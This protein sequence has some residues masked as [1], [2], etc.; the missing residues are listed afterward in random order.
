[1]S[2]VFD[3]TLILKGEGKNRRRFLNYTSRKGKPMSEPINPDKLTTSLHNSS[4]VE[5]AVSFELDT[6]GRPFRVREGGESWTQAPSQSDKRSEFN[7]HAESIKANK[8]GDFHNPY[9]FIPAPPGLR[10]CAFADTVPV[11]NDRFYFDK[12]SG[13]LNV[14]MT[15]ETPVLLHDTARITY[16]NDPKKGISEHKSYPIRVRSLLDH[17][18]KLI[19]EN[20]KNVLVPDITPT[21]V[22][23]MLRAAYEAITN[24]RFSVFKEHDERLAYRMESTEGA[25]SVPAR[26][27]RDPISQKLYVALYTGTSEIG[28]DGRPLNDDDSLSDK[29]REKN[30][31]LC[32][33]WLPMYKT[34]RLGISDDVLRLAK[35]GEQLFA[36]LEKIQHHNKKTNAPDFQY[37]R[38]RKLAIHESSLGHQ[39]EPSPQKPYH[40][41]LNLFKSARGFVCNTGQNI[42][43]KHDERFFFIDGEVTRVKFDAG[44]HGKAWDSLIKNYRREHSEK[45]GALT[46]PPDAEDAG[47]TYKLEWSRHIQR[48]D[49]RE[50]SENARLGAEEL[51]EGSLCY[52]RVLKNERGSF[53]LIELYPVTISRRIHEIS[54]SDLL[55]QE[56]WPA[57]TEEE[58]SPA[59]RLFGWVRQTGSQKSRALSVEQRRV[60]AYRGQLRIGTIK[61][62][63]SDPNQRGIEDFDNELPLQILG[64][65][66]PQQGRFYVAKDKDGRAQERALTNEQAGFRNKGIK[67]LRGRKV[68]PHH[69]VPGDYWRPHRW[70]SLTIEANGVSYYQ[71]YRRPEGQKQRDKQNRSI[72]GWIPPKTEF[73]FDIHFMNLTTVELGALVW[74]LDL[75]DKH[76][77][78][79]G[80]GKPLG[81]GSVR[82]DLL[83]EGSEILSGESIKKRYE[84]LEPLDDASIPAS[85]FKTEF[86]NAFNSASRLTDILTAF[87]NAAK[88]FNKPIHYPRMTLQPLAEGKNFEWFM[89][90]SRTNLK[91]ANGEVV[92]SGGEDVV[93]VRNGYSLPD[94]F[95]E[96]GLPFFELTHPERRKSK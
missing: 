70:S 47:S 73:I 64:Q 65:P 43:N 50:V 26:I 23:G 42:K 27:Q 25:R 90:N 2:E 76:F 68:Y 57:Y 56:L 34:K 67:G 3:G 80:G 86:E 49:Y 44:R 51:R 15:V 18:G 16:T 75:P 84:S 59:D 60:G 91:R 62:L 61:L 17:Q 6:S 85:Q 8:L 40:R 1:M 88:G 96:I 53:D 79:F 35:H 93:E 48:T 89:A 10:T 95:N 74:L 81:F 36:W 87:K 71:E 46:E 7:T 24:S 13:K 4:D 9:N 55:P 58:L 21:S 22:K 14:K 82:L 72:K 19:V 37:W 69:N 32:A 92:K 45:N 54:P 63:E 28:P 38:V 83:E 31:L 29:E 66:K 12:Y 78:R 94:L 41:P 39:P 11:G 20:G 77:H 33:A 5:V 30:G 52:A